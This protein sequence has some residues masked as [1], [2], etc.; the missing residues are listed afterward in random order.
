MA[1]WYTYAAPLM[2]QPADSAGRRW[3]VAQWH[4]AVAQALDA[5]AELLS[6]GLVRWGGITRPPLTY[7]LTAGVVTL[8]GELVGI[9]GDG[10]A[11][12]HLPGG[13]HV[14]DLGAAGSGLPDGT[15]TVVLAAVPV[16]TSV[17]FDTPEVP[18]RDAQ[19]V[20][21]E[22]VEG[23]S[24]TYQPRARLGALDVVEGQVG[25]AG[26]YAVVAYVT[27]S[28]GTWSGLTP[29]HVRPAYH[30][31]DARPLDVAGSLSI[32]NR[33]NGA[34]LVATAAATITLPDDSAPAF[35][36]RGLRFQV[37]NDTASDTVTLDP[38]G[39]AT[40][41]TRGGLVDVISRGVVEVVSLGGG[42]WR[43]FGDLE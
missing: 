43:A 13:T 40:L 24:I 29:A 6:R 31:D 25:S 34:L 30:A 7:D 36:R 19:G 18:L 15:H 1:N 8:T 32:T 12:L 17:A 9:T 22:Q 10:A 14:L 35:V 4:D 3:Y 16:T 41:Q 38:D 5:R 21:V 11:P 37:L 33:H 2:D 28:G 39:T 42:A 26:S 27:L 20:I 23:Q